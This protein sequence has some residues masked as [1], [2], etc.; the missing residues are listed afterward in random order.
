MELHR[1]DNDKN[2]QTFIL[3]VA[4]GQSPDALQ[5]VMV[6]LI[7]TE[8]CNQEDWYD[9]VLTDQMVCAGY[10]EGGR[11]SCQ[12]TTYQLPTLV[13]IWAFRRS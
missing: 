10:E 2:Y 5:Q 7:G 6:P 4:G 9:H 1:A 8:T 13:S 3:V 12:V 11:D